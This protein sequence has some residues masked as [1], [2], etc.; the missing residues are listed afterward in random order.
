MKFIKKII[1]L[2]L[3]LLIII[4]IT[5]TVLVFVVDFNEYKPLITDQVEQATGRKLT[6]EGDIKLAVWPWLG[7]QVVDARLS[8]APA[9]ALSPSPAWRSLI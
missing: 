9:L 5:L 4:L 6:I 1:G 3:A 8:N 7:V 2:V